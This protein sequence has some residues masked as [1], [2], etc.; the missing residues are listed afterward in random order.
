MRRRTLL[1]LISLLLASTSF[2]MVGDIYETKQGY[3]GG[4][5]REDF[6]LA[7]NML[8]QKD[9]EALYKMIIEGRLHMFDDGEKVQLVDRL[10]TFSGVVKVRLVG[11][12]EVLWTNCEAIAYCP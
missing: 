8:Q 7:S 1:G 2:A 12:T 3:P 10:G 6:D 4:I 9:R 5:S 11:G